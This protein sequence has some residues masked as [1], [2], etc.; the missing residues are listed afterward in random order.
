MSDCVKQK[1]LVCSALP[2]FVTSSFCDKEYVQ[3]PGNVAVC[4]SKD[5]HVEKITSI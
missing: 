1:Q 5:N 2:M 4:N 3:K